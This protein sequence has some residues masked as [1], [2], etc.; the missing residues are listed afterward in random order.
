MLVFKQSNICLNDHIAFY[1]TAYV[2][3]I[4]DKYLPTQRYKYI[5]KYS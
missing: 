3:V 2:Q 4:A 5:I 1:K